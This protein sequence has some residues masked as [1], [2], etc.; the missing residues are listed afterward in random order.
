MVNRALELSKKYNTVLNKYGVNSALRRL[1]FFTQLIAESNGKPQ[2]ESLYYTTING[3]KNTFYSPFKGKSNTFIASYLR[4][5]EKMANYVYANR[6]GNGNEVSGDGFKYRGRGF[7]QNTFKD[8]YVKLSKE[9][10]VDF[11]KN[12]DLLNEEA[13][14]MLAALIYWRDSN[15]NKYADVNDLDGVSDVV[16]IGRKTLKHGDANGFEHRQKVYNNLKP[17]FLI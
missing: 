4:N 1:H 14:A 11:I 8:Q 10:G 13:N 3:A 17:Y 15:L 9:L 7:F 6:G 12:P 2:S 16:N 5:S